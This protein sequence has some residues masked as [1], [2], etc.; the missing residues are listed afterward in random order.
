MLPGGIEIFVLE[1]SFE[2]A[3]GRYEAGAWLRLPDGAALDAHSVEG[4]ML[5]AKSGAVGSLRAAQRT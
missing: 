3:E 1:G 4:C 2:D 5:Y